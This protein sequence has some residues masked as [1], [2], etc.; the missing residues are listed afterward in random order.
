MS[1]S[2]RK[3]TRDPPPPNAAPRM[4]TEPEGELDYLYVLA[5]R[6]L[7]AGDLHQCRVWLAQ[8]MSSRDLLTVETTPFEDPIGYSANRL[9][10]QLERRRREFQQLRR[11]AG[12]GLA[13]LSDSPT[14]IRGRKDHLKGAIWRR[15][16]RRFQLRAYVC[17]WGWE[18]GFFRS[19]DTLAQRELR[20]DG[21][22]NSLFEDDPDDSSASYDPMWTTTH[23]T[24]F[25]EVAASEFAVLVAD[26]TWTGGEIPYDGSLIVEQFSLLLNSIE[27][28]GVV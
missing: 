12:V 27:E 18:R 23:D 14:I 6:A 22:T 28:N 7:W 10:K 21:D 16:P 9:R 8:L 25:V 26:G 13:A 19:V 5:H 3:S 24:F 17:D 4:P 2:G 11:A 15:G 1:K 20:R